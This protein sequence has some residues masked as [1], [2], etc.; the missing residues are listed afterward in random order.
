VDVAAVFFVSLLITLAL[1]YGIARER[2]DRALHH[3]DPAY[4]NFRD[5]REALRDPT[6]A[7]R[8]FP[9][10]YGHRYG[11]TF[12]P[13]ADP[14]AEQLRRRAVRALVEAGIVGFAGLIGA[15][16]LFGAQ[17]RLGPGVAE[18]VVLSV[19][20]LLGLYWTRVL[21]E[22]LRDPDKPPLIT[23]FILIGAAVTAA[24]IIITVLLRAGGG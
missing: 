20:V 4:R 16:L 6:G 9:R 1:R 18:L 12:R 17:R 24:A 5:G 2:F 3:V 14:V 8:S 10:T 19:Q 13:V 23:L 21:Q 11:V 15:A 22:H 7:F